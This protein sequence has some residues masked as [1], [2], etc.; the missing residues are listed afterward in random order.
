MRHSADMK[1]GIGHFLVAWSVDGTVLRGDPP[2][3]Q[4]PH[5]ELARCLPERG[6][7]PA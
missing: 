7:R 5:D 2:L 3:T 6:R 4:A 1:K